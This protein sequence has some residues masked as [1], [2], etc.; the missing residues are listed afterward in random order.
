MKPSTTKID[1]QAYREQIDRQMAALGDRMDFL[2][3]EKIAIMECYHDLYAI[4][5]NITLA[6]KTK[7][8]N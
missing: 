4:C 3:S 1:V 5:E 6:I 2:P 8:L 7:V